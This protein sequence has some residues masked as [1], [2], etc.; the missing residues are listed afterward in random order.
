MPSE[1]KSDLGSLVSHPTGV[2]GTELRLLCEQQMLVTA[3]LLLQHH[4]YFRSLTRIVCLHV[5]A[6]VCINM[7]PCGFIYEYVQIE[8]EHEWKVLRGGQSSL[9]LPISGMG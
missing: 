2:L 9:F 1:T 8:W 6:C 4:A 7:C 3:E 5:C